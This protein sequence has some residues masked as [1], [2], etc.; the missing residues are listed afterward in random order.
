MVVINSCKSQSL[1]TPLPGALSLFPY[2]SQFPFDNRLLQFLPILTLS[3]ASQE[4]MSV[5][6][7]NTVKT[8]VLRPAAHQA[9]HQAAHASSPSPPLTKANDS[10]DSGITAMPSK[11][12]LS[13]HRVNFQSTKTQICQM[14]C[15]YLID[16]DYKS[17][18]LGACEVYSHVGKSRT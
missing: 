1:V 2:S 9:A 11:L 4:K 7:G 12:T 14:W 6:P 8:W 15:F 3:C 13:V 5:I 16:D 17:T 10:K 18:N